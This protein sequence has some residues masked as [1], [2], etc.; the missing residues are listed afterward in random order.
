MTT[1]FLEIINDSYLLEH[2][3]YNSETKV[4]RVLTERVGGW[5][6]VNFKGPEESEH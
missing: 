5:K 3:T 2:S 4:F 1:I 6:N